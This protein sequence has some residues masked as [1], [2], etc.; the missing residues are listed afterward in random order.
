M[1]QKSSKKE[2][3]DPLPGNDDNFWPKEADNQVHE[4]QLKTCANG[5]HRLFRTKKANQVHCDCGAGY[6]LSP[7]WE[8]T[9][10]GQL[11]VH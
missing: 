3:L 11:V 10:E 6:I 8:I 7:G 4:L 5:S 2:K 9:N 1:D